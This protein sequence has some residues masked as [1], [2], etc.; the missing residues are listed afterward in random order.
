M[1]QD[2][3]RLALQEVR[4]KLCRPGLVVLD[5]R[6]AEEW[7]AAERRIFRSLRL[8]PA[9]DFDSMVGYWDRSKSYVVYCDSP[10]QAVSEAACSSLRRLGVHCWVLDGGWEAWQAAGYPTEARYLAQDAPSKPELTGRFPY[11]RR[12][13]GVVRP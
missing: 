5:A 10:G 11:D 9:G 13:A 3:P 12:S 1:A 4:D 8:D 6:Q 2:V 7:E